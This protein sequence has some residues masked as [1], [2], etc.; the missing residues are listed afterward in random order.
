M[1]GPGGTIL[2]QRRA[3]AKN[4]FY[5]RDE[6]FHPEIPRHEAPVQEVAAP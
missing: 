3:L 2:E 1:L 4:P 6:N 5:F